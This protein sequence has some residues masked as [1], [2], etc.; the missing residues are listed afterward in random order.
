MPPT[1][2]VFILGFY[3]ELRSNVLSPK[4]LSPTTLTRKG[5][6]PTLFTPFPYFC[7][8]LRARQYL[9]LPVCSPVCLSIPNR[10]EAPWTQGHSQWQKRAWP[11]AGYKYQQ[12]HKHKYVSCK[13]AAELGFV[14]RAP[15]CP[16][17]T[18]LFPT[19][20]KRYSQNL[21]PAQRS[22]PPSP[23]LPENSLMQTGL[24]RGV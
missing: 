6:Q 5:P 10:V 14:P 23:A 22:Q 17:P 11:P 1:L 18:E 24:C 19:A 8:L 7:F 2:W 20:G 15:R 9:T 3:L 4:S 13:S 16:P 12:K 21:N